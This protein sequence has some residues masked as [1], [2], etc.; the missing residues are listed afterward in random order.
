MQPVSRRP[1]PSLPKLIALGASV[2]VCVVFGL[3]VRDRGSSSLERSVLHGSTGIKYTEDGVEVRWRTRLSKVSIDASIEKLGPNAAAAVQQAFGT[4]LGSNPKLPDLSFDMTRGARVELEP[5]GK[6][7]VLLA[8][9]S[10]RGHEDDLAVTLTY[11]DATT[12][13]IIEADIV[14]NSK[15]A[16]RVLQSDE[17]ASSGAEKSELPRSCARSGASATSCS[18]DAYDLQNIVT[19]EVGHFFGLGEEMTDDG[20]S[21]FYCSSRCETHKRSLN[22]VDATSISTLYVTATESGAEP[23]T[24]SQAGCG[25]ARLVPG[26]N[27]REAAL[28]ISSA[29]LLLARRRREPTRAAARLKR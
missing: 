21:M 19:H 10:L 2:A 9:I 7:T 29:L 23:P 13:A 15:H 24:E 5:D 11:S 26:G 12:G 20:A 18:G 1:P 14:I 28:A 4:W 17:G 25:G 8:P 27:L 6:S 3:A 16:F 22:Q